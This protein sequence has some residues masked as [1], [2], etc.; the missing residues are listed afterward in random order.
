M[1]DKNLDLLQN[2]ISGQ[3]S[4]ELKTGYPAITVHEYEHAV[5]VVRE[6]PG[7]VEVLVNYVSHETFMRP[8]R[9]GEYF[10]T[11]ELP[12]GNITG[13]IIKVTNNIAIR[14]SRYIDINVYWLEP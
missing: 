9:V 11:Q 13:K 6:K 4:K 10:S 5:Y 3:V 1:K 14:G 2:S 12:G 8:F 7:I